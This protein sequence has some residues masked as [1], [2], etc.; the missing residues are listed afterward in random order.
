MTRVP[1]VENPFHRA[2]Y[3][4]GPTASGKTAVG[5]ALA[6]LLNA[7]VIALDSMTLYR[8]MDIGTAKPTPQER[9]GVPHHQI[10]VLDP[11]ESWSVADYR[12]QA[13]EIVAGIEAKGKRA[14]F[15]G[16]TALY[17]KALLRGLFEGPAADPGL[18]DELEREAEAL[19]D[20]ALHARL[21]V[22][23]P[24]TAARLHPND[25]RR[26]VRALEVAALTGRPLSTFQNEHGRHAPA[27][28][29][30][31]A[32]ERD[33][34][35]L[36]GRIDRRVV[37]MFDQ[38]FVEEVRRLMNG[39]HP[40]HIVP[41]QAVGYREV[42]DLLE[43]RASLP[44]TVASIQLR[45]RQFAKRQR[46]WVR[47]LAEVRPWPVATDDEPEDIAGRLAELILLKI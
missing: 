18:R 24:I 11:R 37:Q 20:P 42:I 44:E 7:E 1:S 39:P 12:D 13:T 10:D 6:K 2:I 36:C 38:G 33:R 46:T 29:H 8:G 45:T 28:V 15:V 3:L 14:L 22:V 23:D 32:M 41:A 4:T 5:V 31:F 47:G 19:G 43:G 17:M 26:V 40:L 34:G 9:Q 21:A 16:G 35:E 27:G 25:R 30:V